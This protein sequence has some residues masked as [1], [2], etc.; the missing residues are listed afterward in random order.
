MEASVGTFGGVAF[1]QS[2]LGVQGPWFV[3]GILG[4]VPIIWGVVII[5]RFIAFCILSQRLCK[6]HSRILDTF[7]GYQSQN[8]SIP[9]RTKGEV[10]IQILDQN[11]TWVQ[12]Q[13]L[14]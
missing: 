11:S 14:D 4:L 8:P 12:L 9:N 7:Y 5:L 10:Q 3:G 1:L 2:L 13:V 6:S